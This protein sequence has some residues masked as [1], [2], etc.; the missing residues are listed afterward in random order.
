M[1]TPFTSAYHLPEG[2]PFA[3]V[4]AGFFLVGLLRGQ[5]IY[6][7]ARAVTE[8]ALRGTAGNSA[9]RLHTWLDGPTV[10]RARRLLERIGWPLI[11]L[12][13]LTIGVQTVILSAAGVVR[14]RWAL[15]TLAQLPGVLAWA[16]IY[17]T[18]GLTAWAL[19]VR[20]AALSWELWA[21]LA[22]AV[23]ALLAARA[24]ARRWRLPSTVA[25]DSRTRE[26]NRHPS[27]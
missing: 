24:L 7:L 6:W 26:Q 14:M 19:L 12:C 11:P 15:F 16:G 23:L 4:Y 18:I 22:V 9:S 20:R 10:G 21:A 13:Y 2:F 1:G 27:C 17:S 5:A 3:L 25:T 8:G